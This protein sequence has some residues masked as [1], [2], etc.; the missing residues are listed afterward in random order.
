[1]ATTFKLFKDSG[2][3]Q[4]FIPG[5]DFIGPVTNPPE[6]FSIWLGSN[7]AANKAEAD[8]DPGNDQ[9]TVSIT[10]SDPGNNLEDSDVQLGTD[11]ASAAVATGG[12]SLDLGTVINGGVGNAQEIA[13]RVSYSGG[14]T[15]D[16]TVGIALNTLRESV[17]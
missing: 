5:T 8:S 4:E 15:S 10:D 9:I 11:A 1:M 14:L 12:A 7:T 3:T 13:V 2:L 6:T 17:I 16:Q